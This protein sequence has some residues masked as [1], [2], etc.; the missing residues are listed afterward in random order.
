MITTNHCKAT[1]NLKSRSGMSA[2]VLQPQ[3]L[4]NGMMPAHT[5]GTLL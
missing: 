2:A 3:A 1:V 4:S 5:E